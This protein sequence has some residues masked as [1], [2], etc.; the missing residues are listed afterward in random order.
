MVPFFQNDFFEKQSFKQFV[1]FRFW[2]LLEALRRCLVPLCFFDQ[3]RAKKD[4]SF[5]LNMKQ[6]TSKRVQTHRNNIKPEPTK[7]TKKKNT[8]KN[9][10]KHQPQTSTSFPTIYT[11]QS[12][13]SA[14]RTPTVSTGNFSPMKLVG[15][16]ERRSGEARESLVLRSSGDFLSFW[17]LGKGALFRSF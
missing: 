13:R 15:D 12:T 8:S 17:A 4:L 10:P 1:F 11:W 16:V 6:K 3:E 5:C 7:H 2:I 14:A 9:N